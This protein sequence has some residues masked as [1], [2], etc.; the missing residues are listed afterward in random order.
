MT[1][2]RNFRTE[3]LREKFAR[4][5]VLNL[6]FVR[7]PGKPTKKKITIIIVRRWPANGLV[8]MCST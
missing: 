5:P 7:L 8:Q 4:A 6:L 3:Q 2:L 1:L